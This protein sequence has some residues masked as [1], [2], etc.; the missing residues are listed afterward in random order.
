MKTTPNSAVELLKRSDPIAHE[1]PL[2]PEDLDALRGRVTVLIA[3]AHA[4][5]RARPSALPRRRSVRRV[6]VL[7]AAMLVAFAV[8]LLAAPGSRRQDAG[9]LS[10]TAAVAAEEPPTL[11]PTGSF[12]YLD[13]FE[14]QSNRLVSTAQAFRTDVRWWVAANGSGRLAVH[15]NDGGPASYSE[16]F[17]AGRYDA[18]AYPTRAD[19]IGHRFAPPVGAILPLFLGFVPERLP[20][21]PTALSS[22]IKAEIVKAAREQRYGFFNEKSVP[23]AA[24]E[25]QTI[26]YALQDPMDS[27]ALRS[28]LFT[29]AGKVPGITVQEHATDP[30]GR[31]GE[32]ITASEGVA[33][34]ADGKLNH[35][36][37]E[38]FAVIFDPT[39][40]QVLAETQYPSDH[41]TEERDFYTVFTGQRVVASDTATSSR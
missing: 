23:A 35:S 20:S 14:L 4:S 21:D 32:A 16:R 38:L 31:S 22:A 10:E 7:A 13:A 36:A 17:G 12:Y 29:V 34:E 27:P 25:L 28:A 6:A 19:A 9:P 1:R 11:A 15:T 41:P 40:T 5:A 26:A 24:K 37:R 18:I 8:V 33:V 30:L 2:G 39:T 3:D